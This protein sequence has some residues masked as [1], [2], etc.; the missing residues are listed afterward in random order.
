MAPPIRVDGVVTRSTSRRRKSLSLQAKPRREVPPGEAQEGDQYK[1]DAQGE[2]DL[3]DPEGW[4]EDEDG[5]EGTEDAPSGR[6]GVEAAGYPPYAAEALGRHPDRVGG[7][8]AQ[9]RRGGRQQQEGGEHGAVPLAETRV[10]DGLQDQ[11]RGEGDQEDEHAGG[12]GDQGE[13][14]VAGPPV[15]EPPPGVVSD[16]EGGHHDANQAAP[17]EDAVAE[18]GG[19]EPAPDQLESHH[20]GAR[21]EDREPDPPDGALSVRHAWINYSNGE[22]YNSSRGR[23]TNRS[24]A[25]CLYDKLFILINIRQE[26]ARDIL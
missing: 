10:V 19:E 14:P 18:G 15:G 9:Q 22:L 13:G 3:P 11:R 24:H 12:E 5:E 20:H 17:D 25:G 8:H 4:D 26:T 6:D 23:K 7:D 21:D 2:D 16:G 1:Y